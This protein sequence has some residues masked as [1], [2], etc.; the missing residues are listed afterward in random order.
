M[1]NLTLE[2]ELFIRSVLV[3]GYLN[4]LRQLLLPFYEISDDILIKFKKDRLQS[5]KNNRIS[6]SNV[7]EIKLLEEQIQKLELQTINHNSH[8][9]DSQKRFSVTADTIAAYNTQL[10]TSSVVLGTV[11][12][13][14]YM[15]S[16]VGHSTGVELLKTVGN[17][18]L[19]STNLLAKCLPVVSVLAE[20]GTQ[21][22]NNRVV[23]NY[24]KKLKIL[25]ILDNTKR[26]LLIH[27]QGAVDYYLD[28]VL[29]R[30]Q[31]IM[32]DNQIN[33]RDVVLRAY[34]DQLALHKQ[35]D[36]EE[37]VELVKEEYFQNVELVR[38]GVEQVFQAKV[39]EKDELI[40]TK[41][42]ALENKDKALSE[43]DEVIR[44]KETRLSELD[45]ELFD[46]NLE[47]EQ[48]RKQLDREI[49]DKSKQI[50]SLNNSIVSLSE[51]LSFTRELLEKEKESLCTKEKALQES[52]KG[53]LNASL[54]AA[55]DYEVSKRQELEATLNIFLQKQSKLQDELNITE[56][57]LSTKVKELES[58]Q[59]N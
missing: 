33:T 52:L 10:N 36:V 54:Q 12:T 29:N 28:N 21:M 26:S 41:D 44:A 37:Q 46:L 55:Y 22:N 2:E 19:K 32:M 53:N 8:R 47:L 57:N 49:A 6:G 17:L 56:T 15:T 40:S 5:L 1:N 24:E 43:K 38:R 50:T 45:Q 14:R 7:S 42:K 48:K 34:D 51:N 16:F 11:E 30:L 4:N 27:E 13:V 9:V 18:G 25:S 35:S 3:K 23:Y 59:E 20:A 58:E 31:S 39:D